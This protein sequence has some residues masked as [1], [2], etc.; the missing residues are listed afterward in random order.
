MSSSAFPDFESHEPYPFQVLPDGVH[1]ADELTFRERF[2]K[3]FPDSQVRPTI[4]H[5]FFLLRR[6]AQS[7]GLTATQWVDG[8]FVES[9]LEPGDVD[10]VSF[11]DYD[12]LNALAPTVQTFVEQTMNGG[13]ATKAKYQTHTFLVPSCAPSHSFFPVFEQLRGYWREWFGQTREEPIRPGPKL[14]SI[15][16]GIVE[17]HLGD[18]K[19]APRIPT[20]RRTK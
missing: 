15:P 10:L 16:K 9:K 3:D 2:V 14:R 20:E 12:I 8:S 11:I 19:L 7:Q 13:E 1:S 17:L 6:E 18:P 4:C 5:G